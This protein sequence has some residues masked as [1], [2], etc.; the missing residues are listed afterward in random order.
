M[1][2]ND[3]KG[4]MHRLTLPFYGQIQQMTKLIFFLFFTEN[5]LS[6]FMQIVS[7]GD[8][9]IKCQSQFSGKIQEK[10][11]KM[12]SAENFT[13]HAEHLLLQAAC[14]TCQ[15]MSQLQVPSLL[16]NIGPNTVHQA[17]TLQ[18]ISSFSTYY[19]VE[20][21]WLIWLQIRGI[22]KYRIRPNYRTVRLS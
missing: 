4:L 12:S 5:R 11:F 17:L 15:H 13:W 20:M 19:I 3:P 1:T 14:V 6:H 22:L 2:Q 16:Y 9:C 21:T 8:N 18:K 10:Y 7:R